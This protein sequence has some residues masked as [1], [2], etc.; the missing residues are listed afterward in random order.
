MATNLVTW[1]NRKSPLETAQEL[2]K[3]NKELQKL[4]KENTD[5]AKKVSELEEKQKQLSTLNTKLKS[6]QQDYD[7]QI[8]NNKKNKD[9]IDELRRSKNEEEMKNRKAQQ[10]I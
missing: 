6:L 9:K 3:A 10:I 4:S 1:N 7:Q 5:M 2:E 8:A